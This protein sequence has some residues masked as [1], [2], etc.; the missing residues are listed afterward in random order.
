[1]F[2]T[3]PVNSYHTMVEE[4]VIPNSQPKSSD[5]FHES[6]VNVKKKCLQVKKV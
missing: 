5:E 4:H 6:T 2:V 1:M 3:L